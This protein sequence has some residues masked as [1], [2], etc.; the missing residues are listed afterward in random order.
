MQHSTEVR[1]TPNCD[2][3]GNGIR[4]IESYKLA[5][6]HRRRRRLHVARVESREQQP[7]TRI[8]HEYEC[9]AV[10]RAKQKTSLGAKCNKIKFSK[11][12]T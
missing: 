3:V 2:D 11:Y 7:D 5:E 10:T 9:G 8:S 6:L 1:N 4:R 12:I